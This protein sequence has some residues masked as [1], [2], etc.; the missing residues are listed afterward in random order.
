MK[1]SIIALVLC[2]FASLSIAVTFD[3]VGTRKR[4]LKTYGGAE[5][6]ATGIVESAYSFR[7][8]IKGWPAIIGEDI[9]VRI[10]GLQFPDIVTDQVDPN[11][12][13]KQQAIKFLDGFLKDA[14]KIELANIRRGKDFALVADVI[15]DANS[16]AEILI[17]KGLAKKAEK[18][19]ETKAPRIQKVINNQTNSAKEKQQTASENITWVAS[20][21]SKIFHKSTCS[22]AKRLKPG[23]AIKFPTRRKAIETG[24]RPCK[25]CKP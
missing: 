15:V 20:S 11:K 5:V 9:P 23:T 8:N 24:R 18:Q 19:D 1:K 17:Q 3:E 10:A 25:T 13:F 4:D 22:F 16:L 14:K 2:V 6:S 12:F 21:D 7:C